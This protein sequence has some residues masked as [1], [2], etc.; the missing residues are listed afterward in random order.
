MDDAA[1]AATHLENV[2]RVRREELDGYQ[3]TAAGKLL[4][5][6][7]PADV[8][9]TVGGMFGRK[10]SVKL[11]RDLATES[12]GDPEA[13]AGLRKA[14]VDHMQSKLVSNTEAGTSGQNL[15]KTDA[16][17]KFLGDNLPA[18]RQLFS[19]EEL[20]QWQA[21][22]RDLKRANRSVVAVK[23]PGQSNTAQDFAAMGK[24]GGERPTVLRILG[25]ALGY[26]G[27]A[28]FPVAGGLAGGIPGLL[29]GFGADYAMRAVEGARSAG[30]SKMDELLT[31]A[32]LNPD[33]ARALLAKAPK[34][35]DAAAGTLA[36]A[37]RAT[38]ITAPAITGQRQ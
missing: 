27:H 28:V 26:A 35:P 18:L 1:G 9:K 15:L 37:L 33:V 16:F 14:V 34:R 5:V 36:R 25:H 10:D 7:D 4:N 20:G 30:I 22:A 12:K 21:I 6:S 24:H 3:K 17:Q 32:M 23:L 29:A 11:F 13:L 2:A 8:T 38:A 19:E 31:E